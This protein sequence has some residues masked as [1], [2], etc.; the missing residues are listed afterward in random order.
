MIFPAMMKK[1][2]AINEK[3]FTPP[4][5]FITIRFKGRSIP[6]INT[7]EVSN[8]AKYTGRPV[9]IN[10]SNIANIPKT[11]HIVSLLLVTCLSVF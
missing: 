10:I 1:G 5:I 9:K 6:S 3:E 2:I 11:C 4:N 7:I 8:N